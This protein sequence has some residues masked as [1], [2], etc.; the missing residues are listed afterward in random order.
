MEQQQMN[1]APHPAMMPVGV[2]PTPIDPRP[3]YDGQMFLADRVVD[4]E[5]VKRHV[6]QP[7]VR[8]NEDGL[9]T[10]TNPIPTNSNYF[11]TPTMPYAVEF[12]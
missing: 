5:Y 12:K 4:L 1:N 8:H 9:I 3:Q 11:Y 2:A 10:I 7:V 6:G